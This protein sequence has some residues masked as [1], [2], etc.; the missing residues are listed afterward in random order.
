[1]NSKVFLKN[2]LVTILL[3]LNIIIFFK[4][5]TYYTLPEVISEYF[6][7]KALASIFFFGLSLRL[8][9]VLYILRGKQGLSLYYL[10]GVHYF[11]IVSIVGGMLI[12]LLS[13]YILFDSIAIYF[14]AF[15][16]LISNEIVESYMSLQRLFNS[17]GKMILFRLILLIKPILL[18]ILLD[19]E[20]IILDSSAIII[21]YETTVLMSLFIIYVLINYKHSYHLIERKKVL[22]S[23]IDI[24]RNTWLTSIS[25]IS[26]DALPNYLL[27]FFVSDLMYAQYNIARKMYGIIHSAQLS[28][29]QVFNTISVELKDRFLEYLKKY[30][31]IMIILNVFSFLGLFILGKFMINLFTKEIYATDITV[32]II[33]I[34]LSVIFLYIL[35]YPVRQ[36]FILNKMIE[37]NNQG[38]KISMV[39]VFFIT[40]IT[41]PIFGVYAA[42]IIHPL[43]LI[44]PIVI[45]LL[46]IRTSSRKIIKEYYYNLYKV[47]F[48]KP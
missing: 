21:A 36:W 43:G 38:L 20:L 8:P 32:Y 23:N 18:L 17:Y 33:F 40:I 39:L 41:V 30:Y 16:I 26:F 31:F 48:K 1:M 11:F 4:I 37:A 6:A 13:S 44:L 14:G 19:F 10:T 7:I 42:A 22:I 2:I 45:T 28:F 25:K 29:I 3:F 9:E 34:F 46:V 47:T 35:L 24:L 5:I 12:L 15:F 27:S